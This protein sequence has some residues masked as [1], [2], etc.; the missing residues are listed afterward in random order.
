MCHT[1]HTMTSW[2]KWVLWLPVILTF[3]VVV[4]VG[5]FGLEEL[6]SSPATIVFGAMMMLIAIVQGWLVGLVAV[7][8]AR[9]ADRIWKGTVSRRASLY[10]VLLVH[11]LIVGGAVAVAVVIYLN[12]TAPRTGDLPIVGPV[13]VI[14]VVAA[15][16][17]ALSAWGRRRASVG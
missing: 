10:P 5:G 8:A 14:A 9:I 3:A 16:S 11:A 15:V 2:H 1:L 7:L 6:A 17:G 13:F 12:L 4:T